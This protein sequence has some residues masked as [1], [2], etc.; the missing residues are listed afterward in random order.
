[1]FNIIFLVTLCQPFKSLRVRL[2]A[3]TKSYVKKSELR[4]A[5]AS[6]YD[7]VIYRIVSYQVKQY[8]TVV[9]SSHSLMHTGVAH[10]RTSIARVVILRIDYIS[11]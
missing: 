4:S 8:Q 5:I 3:D 9:F 1:M 10:L 6:Q 2:K 7:Q 11:A